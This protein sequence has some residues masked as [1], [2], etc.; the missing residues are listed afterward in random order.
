[1]KKFGLI[2]AILFMLTGCGNEENSPTTFGFNK[3]T[4]DRFI[5]IKTYSDAYILADKETRVMYIL[6]YSIGSGLTPLL[7]NNGE[8]QYYDSSVNPTEEKY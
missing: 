8:I 3:D 7:D 1:M 5:R 4:S 6:F 2:V